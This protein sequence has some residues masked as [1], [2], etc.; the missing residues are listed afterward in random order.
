MEKTKA[1]SEVSPKGVF[2]YPRL[3]TPDTKFNANGVYGLKLRLTSEA[4]QPLVEMIDAAIEAQ[5]ESVKA[6]GK[7]KGKVKVKYSDGQNNWTGRSKKPL[8]V[9]DFLN[10][11]GNLSSIEV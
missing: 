9:V 3:T 6:S 2:Q 10:K 4:A 8:W 5:V 7:V 11:G 1:Q